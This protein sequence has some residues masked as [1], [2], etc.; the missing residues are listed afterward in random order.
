MI[1]QRARRL[2]TVLVGLAGFVG[3]TVVFAHPA[4]AGVPLGWPDP[5]EIDAWHAILVFAVGP[6]GLFVAIVAL[7]YAP[8]VARGESVKPGGSTAESQWLGG[9]RRTAGELAGPD[10]EDS[11]AGGAGGTW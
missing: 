1:S 7:V 5:P 8:A 9:P 6:I 11:R 2:V 4:S 3:A 10:D